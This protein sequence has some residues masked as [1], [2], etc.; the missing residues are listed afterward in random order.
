MCE[1]YCWGDQFCWTS[2]LEV[3]ITNTESKRDSWGILF[4]IHYFSICY[5]IFVLWVGSF[6]KETDFLVTQ[7]PSRGGS[8]LYLAAPGIRIS[9]IQTRPGILPLC[10]VLIC[11]LSRSCGSLKNDSSIAF[12]ISAAAQAS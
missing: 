4:N 5:I 8:S 12:I 1:G 9:R 3:S 10:P 2:A 6:S 7:I 11:K